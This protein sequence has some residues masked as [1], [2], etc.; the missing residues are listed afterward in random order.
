MAGAVLF[1]GGLDSTVLLAR[2]VADGPPV[3]PIHVRSGLA[4]ESAE[5]RAIA[6]LLARPPFL[7]RTEPVVTI[8]VDMRDVYSSTHW[9]IRGDAPAYDTPD[10][11]VYLDGRNIAL[12]SKAGVLCARRGLRTIAIGPLAGNP[13][14]DARPEFFEAFGRALSL[15]LGTDR[16]L[17]IVAPFLALHKADVIALG[18]ELGV[19]LAATLSCMSPAGERHCG[20]CSKCRERQEAFRDAGVPD[21]TDYAA[22]SRLDPS[23]HKS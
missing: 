14:P 13:F 20:R 19:P 1:S 2:Q 9:A 4:W 10:E 17:A 23:P 16:S 6:R 8:D 3:L 5:A 21:P 12:L 15:G 11:D 22:G 7:G 18:I